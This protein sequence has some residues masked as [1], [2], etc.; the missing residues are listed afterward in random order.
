[1]GAERIVVFPDELLERMQLETTIFTPANDAVGFAALS[2]EVGLTLILRLYQLVMDEDN[3]Y[4][5]IQEL[6]AFS[7]ESRIELDQFINRLPEIT[8]LE[9]LTILNP[10]PGASSVS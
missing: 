1:M 3:I 6:A 8:G 4:D 2:E 5:P 10:L 7:F 9:M